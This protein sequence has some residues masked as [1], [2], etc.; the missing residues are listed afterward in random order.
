M[1]I[2]L[3]GILLVILLAFGAT[4]WI[5]SRQDTGM[6]RDAMPEETT[7]P[8]DNDTAVKDATKKPGRVVVLDTSPG[9]IEFVLYEEDCPVTT[10]R[11]TKLVKSGA[12]DG[13]DFP[14]VEFW[15]IQTS[16]AK[17]QVDPMG[18][19]LAK[20]LSHEPGTVGIARTDDPNSGT[21]IFYITIKP[22]HH[23][24]LKYTNFGRVIRGMD[25]VQK[26]KLGDVIKK[27]GLRDLT[28]ADQKILEKL[29]GALK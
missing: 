22:A 25:V 16:A 26:I 4:S 8:M 1:N 3:W 2:R 17:E 18:L 19:E 11:I 6:V 20:G 7:E 27:A 10:A 23:L 29:P 24:D 21:S 5:L 9:S 28:E 13:V 15:V 14:R 12:Y